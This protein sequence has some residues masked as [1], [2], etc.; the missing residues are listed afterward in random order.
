MVN[1]FLIAIAGIVALMAAL[2]LVPRIGSQP[3]EPQ[4][5]L[6]IEYTRLNLT[7]IQDGR[8]VAAS[9]EDLVIKNDRSAVYRNLTGQPDEKRFTIT[10]EEIN[11][12]K[13][14]VLTTGFMQVPGADYPQKD[15]L[16]N[17]TKYM[18]KLTSSD[19]SKTISWVNLE[20][21]EVAVPSI[22]RNIG[23]HLDTIIERHV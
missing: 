2:V 16:A 22:V 1:K 3:A 8:L 19:N 10:S 7:R 15:G 4:L 11:A 18:L 14:L 12:L 6:N 21:S 17:L 5:E 13:G 23:T 20:A 9:A